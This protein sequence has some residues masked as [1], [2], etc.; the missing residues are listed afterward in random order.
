MYPSILLIGGAGVTGSAIARL[1]RSRYPDLGLIIAGRDIEKAQELAS[2][3]D[4][5]AISLDLNAA[6]ASLRMIKPSA[7]A[8]L[9]KDS[10]L[11]G[12]AWS[13]DLGIP[14]I[15]ISSAAFE[16]GLDLVHALARKPSAPVTIAGHW[17]AGA[18]TIA[19]IE[20]ASYFDATHSI[21][22]GITID[23]NAT[24]GGPASA[25]DFER[26][27][28]STKATLARTE[29]SY[30]WESD[31]Q[32]EHPFRSLGGEMVVGNGSVSIDVAAIGAA[33]NA[34]NV[35]I[36][37]HW[38]D[39]HHFLTTGSPADEISIEIEG[40]I[41]GRLSTQRMTLQLPNAAGSLTAISVTIA[42]ERMLG[43]DGSPPVK[44]GIYGPENLTAPADFIARLKQAGVTVERQSH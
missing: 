36:L 30:V 44:A 11:Q 35:R 9:A 4:A 21:T 19:A 16:H 7:V 24:G 6:S 13:Q 28:N 37:E 32:S 33:T 22:A 15:G 26:V 3:I 20:L 25:A 17:F 23:R 38:A 42:L 18:V 40:M 27:S 10:S 29:G 8:M 5:R 31:G 39:S 14:Y 43:L 2:A 41:D 12:L 34:P 1:L